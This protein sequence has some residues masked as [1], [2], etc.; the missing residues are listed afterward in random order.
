MVL[1]NW[2]SLVQ[3]AFEEKT[4]PPPTAY[5]LPSADVL[6]LKRWKA[7]SHVCP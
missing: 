6:T 3:T 7:G 5:T 4:M 2:G 1:R